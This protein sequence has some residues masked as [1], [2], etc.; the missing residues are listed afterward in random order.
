MF[1]CEI[2][3]IVLICQKLGLVAPVQQIIKLPLPNFNIINYPLANCLFKV[4][5]V[6][7]TSTLYCGCF[8]LQW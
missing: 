8:N 2:S 1:I 7:V 3:I 6:D 4:G 5:N